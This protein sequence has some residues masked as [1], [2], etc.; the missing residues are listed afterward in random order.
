MTKPGRLLLTVRDLGET[1]N[2]STGLRNVYLFE[3]RGEIRR[4]LLWWPRHTAAA[5][6]EIAERFRSLGV[7]VTYDPARPAVGRGKTPKRRP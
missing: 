4:V 1:V 2:I 7:R 6:E 3:T 5:A